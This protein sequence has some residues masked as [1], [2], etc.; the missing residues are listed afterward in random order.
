MA[1]TCGLSR[2]TASRHRPG[3]APHGPHRVQ[4]GTENCRATS[5]GRQAWSAGPRREGSSERAAAMTRTHVILVVEDDPGDQLLIREA[6]AEH[7]PD[8]RLE[9]VADGEDALD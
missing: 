8:R 7:S 5:V 4:S 9:I 2:A 1:V 6:F 3:Y